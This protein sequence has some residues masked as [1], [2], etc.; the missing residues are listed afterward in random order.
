LLSELEKFGLL[1]KKRRG[2]G[3]PNI[4]YVKSFLT[5][6]AGERG[7]DLG[8]SADASRQEQRCRKRNLTRESVRRQ[9][10]RIRYFS[11][12]QR[13]GIRYFPRR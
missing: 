11:R 2:K 10:C 4:L 3:L 12:R 8:T 5:G 9:K 13:Y 1:E 7:D 6:I